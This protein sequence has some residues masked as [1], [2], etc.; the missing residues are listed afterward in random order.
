MS[1]IT[2][3]IRGGKVQ[4]IQEKDMQRGD[5]QVKAVDTDVEVLSKDHLPAGTRRVSVIAIGPW[6]PHAVRSDGKTLRVPQWVVMDDGRAFAFHRIFHSAVGD[7]Y[8]GEMVFPGGAVFQP[9]N[10]TQTM[11]LAEQESRLALRAAQFGLVT[12]SLL[13]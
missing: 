1:E 6:T 9:C 2:K 12:P 11:M 4:T 8:P 13:H 10:K 5:M 3:V 7:V